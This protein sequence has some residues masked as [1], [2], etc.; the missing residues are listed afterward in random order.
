MGD[1][2]LGMVVDEMKRRGAR[3]RQLAGDP[4]RLRPADQ[5]RPAGSARTWASRR[6]MRRALNMQAHWAVWYYETYGYWTSVNS[7]IAVW[8]MVD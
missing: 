3:T 2:V 8:A 6:Q 5:R 4:Q 1:A 7:A